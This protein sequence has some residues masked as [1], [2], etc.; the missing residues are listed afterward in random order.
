MMNEKQSGM[1]KGIPEGCHQLAPIVQV[2]VADGCH[3]GHSL[4]GVV[5]LKLN[6]QAF[7]PWFGKAMD[8]VKL[9][10]VGEDVL[11]IKLFGFK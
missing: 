1:G 2:L 3:C 10:A 8:E 6:F 11:S 7:W 5:C 9:T 4:N